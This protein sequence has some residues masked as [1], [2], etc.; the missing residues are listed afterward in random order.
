VSGKRVESFTL[1][2]LDL[3]PWEYRP[4]RSRL[5]LLG[6]WYSTCGP[7]RGAIEHLV[8]LHQTYGGRGL[9]IVGIAYERGDLADQVAYVHAVRNR[10]G[11]N[12]P[13]LLGDGMTCRVKTHLHVEVFP[14]LLL[15]D[16]TGRIVWSSGNEGIAEEAAR[17]DLDIEI[18][19]HLGVQ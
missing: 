4:G 19:R 5:L 18:R 2:D 9:E 1:R 14:T 15:L 7:C 8:Q 16:E 17:H 13:T 11:I 10:Y 3:K 6:F 12:F